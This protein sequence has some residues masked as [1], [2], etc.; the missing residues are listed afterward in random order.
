MAKYMLQFEQTHSVTLVQQ[1][2]RTNYDKE[3]STRKSIYMWH[4]SFAET[5]RYCAKKKISST[6]PN[7]EI[8]KCVLASILRSPHKSARRVS[9]EFCDLSHVTA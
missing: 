6:R 1:W 7:D 3:V 5:G 4:K 2:F 9:M 8:V